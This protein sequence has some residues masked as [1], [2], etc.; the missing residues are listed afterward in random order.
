MDLVILQPPEQHWT[1][2]NCS[3][4]AVT[5]GQPNRFHQCRGLAGILAPMVLDGQRSRVL[6]VEREDY[7]GREIVQ[8][9]GNGRPV[10]AVRTD[11]WDGS[12]DVIVN[13]PTAR[14]A[15]GS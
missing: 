15:G 8:Y 1:C 10:M 7:I 12:N 6:A 3:D 4:T 14:G 13:A 11:H 9:D 5:R 2:G